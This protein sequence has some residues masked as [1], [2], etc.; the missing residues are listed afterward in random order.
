MQRNYWYA[1]HDN[2]HIDNIKFLELH[3]GPEHR[4]QRKTASLNVVLFMTISLGAMF[5]ILY[6]IALFAITIQYIVERYTLAIFYRLPPK[7]SLELTERNT[8]I[9]AFA[10][11]LGMAISFWAFGNYSMFHADVIGIMETSN[12]VL[13]SHHSLGVVIA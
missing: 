4:F 11:L 2:N 1:G 5:P 3:A 13:P 12:D 6:P 9:L 7:F 10:P 8:F